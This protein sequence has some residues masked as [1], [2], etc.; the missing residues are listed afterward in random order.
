MLA[1]FFIVLLVTNATDVP[2]KS[3]ISLIVAGLYIIINSVVDLRADLFQ[4]DRLL[5][6]SSVAAL[7]VIVSFSF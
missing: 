3:V 4:F 7:A 5:E 1:I 2:N 6:Y